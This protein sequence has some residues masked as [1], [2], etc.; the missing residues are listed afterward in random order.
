MYKKLLGMI[1]IVEIEVIEFMYIYG[2]EVV[3]ILINLL[4]IR[5]DDVDLVY[6][7]KKE[8]INLIID[9]I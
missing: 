2:L 1:G 9:R 4:V 7:I 6:K 3:V 5:K 8:K